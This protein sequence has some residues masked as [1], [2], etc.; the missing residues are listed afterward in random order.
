MIVIIIMSLIKFVFRLATCTFTEHASCHFAYNDI[1][2]L[3]YMGVTATDLIS[4]A[5]VD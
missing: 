2:S 4:V 5:I 3:F 1:L